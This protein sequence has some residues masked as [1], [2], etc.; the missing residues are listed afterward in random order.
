MP[1]RAY[2]QPKKAS[3]SVSVNTSLAP[4]LLAFFLGTACMYLFSTSARRDAVSVSPEQGG[5][6]NQAAFPAVLSILKVNDDGMAPKN[7]LYARSFLEGGAP[8]PG[9]LSFGAPVNVPTRGSPSQYSQ[10]GY[11]TNTDTDTSTNGVRVLPLYGRRQ[12]RNNFQY[13][14][15]SDAG[16][17]VKLPLVIGGR[18]STQERGV[19]EVASGDMVDVQSLGKFRTELYDNSSPSYIP[20]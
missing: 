5:S 14:T 16:F 13:Y 2:R 9:P 18:A 1:P 6:G 15:L 3:V 8:A 17:S 4:V 7:D 12:D 20:Y 19:G 10:V 11:L